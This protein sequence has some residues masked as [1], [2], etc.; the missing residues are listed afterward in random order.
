[1]KAGYV[2]TLKHSCGFLR[3]LLKCLNKI[4]AQGDDEGPEHLS[5]GISEQNIR[6]AALQ[7]VLAQK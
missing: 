3:V 5:V 2:R 4:S 7:H 6:E 1:M